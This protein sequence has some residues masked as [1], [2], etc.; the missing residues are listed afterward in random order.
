MKQPSMRKAALGMTGLLVLVGLVATKPAAA[1]PPCVEAVQ[2]RLPASG[3]NRAFTLHVKE[4][5]FSDE[6]NGRTPPPGQRWIT[7]EVRFD[8]WMPSDLVFGLGYPEP[9]LVASLARQLYLL[10][11]DRQVVRSTLSEASD[12]EDE[13]VLP[14][15]GDRRQGQVAFAVPD[16]PLSQLSL[17][18]YHDQYAPI[19]VPLLGERA[20]PDEERDAASRQEGHDLFSLGVHGVSRHDRW[21]GESAPEGMQWLVVDL[22]GQGEWRT[23]VD[24]RAL[25]ASAESGAEVSLRRVMEYIEAPGLLQAVVDGSHAYVRD[26][27]LSTLAG[28]PALLPD[29]WAGGQ[30]VFPVP[31]D[32]ESVELIAYMPEFR[33]TNISSEIRPS[34]RYLLKGEAVTGMIGE[35]LVDIEDGPIR[36]RVH[37]LEFPDEFA[38]HLA[39]EE[40]S[41]LLVEASMTNLSGVGGM[42]PVSQRLSPRGV[43]G[44]L[45]AAYQRGPLVLE[46]PFWLPAD[47]EP[48]RF[49]L[50]YRFESPA[51]IYEFE[52]GGVSVTE[53]VRL[54]V[55]P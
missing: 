44:E 22:R 38:G 30:A 51:E 43:E 35:A 55:E 21:H 12:L 32:A 17:H 1:Q 16:E 39:S 48:R 23:P 53:R 25:D 46:E 47:D 5:A 45:V 27:E 28:D 34:L 31:K 11:D 37:G 2:E 26:L 41:L 54:P 40:E 14:R 19:V 50:L 3:C 49:Q 36:F 9:L 8:S 13:F 20:Q 24:A 42:M 29:A 10:V 52:Y 6:L 15:S 7:L 33:G 18:Y 4:M